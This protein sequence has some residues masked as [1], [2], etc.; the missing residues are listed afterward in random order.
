MI[1]ELEVRFV[2]DENNKFSF[3]FGTHFK[4]NRESL[5][6]K[7]HRDEG[8]IIARRLNIQNELIELFKEELE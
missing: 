2:D 7:L 4:K 8:E 6:K 5:N 1:Y 3:K